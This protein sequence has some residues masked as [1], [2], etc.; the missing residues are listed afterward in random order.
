MLGHA[1]GVYIR[2]D[3][4]PFFDVLGAIIGLA[5]GLCAVPVEINTIVVMGESDETSYSV[6][7]P[8][9]NSPDPGA[10]GVCDYVIRAWR[11]SGL[12]Y[13][14]CPV[15]ANTYAITGVTV[16]DVEQGRLL[17]EQTVIIAGELI[18]AIGPRVEV[19]VP[20]GAQMI[21]GRGTVSDA[22]PRGCARSLLRSRSLRASA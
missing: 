5:I 4:L 9:W 17:P 12:R 13:A 6:S 11:A 10:G 16:V 22:R 3:N 19:V 2:S 1:I 15:S 21:D 18:R 20:D 14:A 8:M 7:H